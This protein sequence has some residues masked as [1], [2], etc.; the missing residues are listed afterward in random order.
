MRGRKDVGDCGGVVAHG[1]AEGY[2]EAAVARFHDGGGEYNG[3]LSEPALHGGDGAG[4][5]GRGVVGEG[6]DGCA[7]ARGEGLEHSQDGRRLSAVHGGEVLDLIDDQQGGASG[8]DEV[9]EPPHHL[10][11][12]GPRGGEVR[13]GV[14]RRLPGKRGR[15][16]DAD[17]TAA[18]NAYLIA[19]VVEQVL[20]LVLVVPVII[21]V[22]GVVLV[23]VGRV[24]GVVVDWVGGGE[25]VCEVD[26]S[27]FRSEEAEDGEHVGLRV[28]VE[29][30]E[31]DGGVGEECV[32]LVGGCGAARGAGGDIECDGG[33]AGGGVP[34]DEGELAEGDAVGPEP[35]GRLLD[36]EVEG[37][38][39]GFLC[40]GGGVEVRSGHETAPGEGVQ[41]LFEG[42]AGALERDAVFRVPGDAEGGD[43]GIVVR[44]AVEPA[45]VGAGASGDA[46]AEGSLEALDIGAVLRR[47][48][49]GGDVAFGHG[50]GLCSHGDM[51]GRRALTAQRA[52]VTYSTSGQDG[53]MGRGT[54]AP[55]R[56]APTSGILTRRLLLHHFLGHYSGSLACPATACGTGRMCAAR[57]RWIP[58]G[59]GMTNRRA[60]ALGS[61]FTGTTGRK[62]EMAR[63]GRVGWGARAPTRDAPTLDTPSTPAAC[64]SLPPL[65]ALARACALPGTLARCPLPGREGSR[66]GRSQGMP[67][68]RAP[69]HARCVRLAAAAVCAGAHACPA[70]HLD[71]RFHGNDE[72]RRE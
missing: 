17:R 11:E 38:E 15:N 39:S 20:L 44:G 43:I 31:D 42:A 37:L 64:G 47:E 13:R 70:G 36:E 7:G 3:C 68:H 55:T 54:R 6:D 51:V 32:R 14:R 33:L 19:V 69:F 5:V 27:E 61:R 25:E 12:A 26:A 2:E 10:V 24:V 29:E 67:L 52:R 8:L 28:T 22:A 49:V 23:V 16:P 72:R 41:H 50:S 56:D 40:T 60:G 46:A 58:A 62:G 4:V 57:A 30:G 59:A 48:H 63:W 53:G 66:R 9:G 71:S 18:G 34:G 65:C 35:V 45:G 21:V 1:G